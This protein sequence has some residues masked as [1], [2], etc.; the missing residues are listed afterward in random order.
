[1]QSLGEKEAKRRNWAMYKLGAGSLFSSLSYLLLS[2]C[3][4]YLLLFVSFPHSL[5]AM[6]HGTVCSPREFQGHFRGKE[7]LKINHFE[8]SVTLN[9]NFLRSEEARFL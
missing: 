9:K 3:A 6:M 2:C 8:E 1:M 7:F 5:N 4:K